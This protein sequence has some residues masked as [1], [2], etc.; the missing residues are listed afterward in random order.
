MYGLKYLH[1]HEGVPAQP[2][3]TLVNGEAH[4]IASPKYTEVADWPPTRNIEYTAGVALLMPWKLSVG[5][6]GTVSE[7][8]LTV[9]SRSSKWRVVSLGKKP[10]S[11]PMLKGMYMSALPGMLP[12]AVTVKV[13]VADRPAASVAVNSTVST[14]GDGLLS[15][16]GGPPV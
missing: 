6:L 3:G 16:G 7:T 4:S 2:S 13:H 11:Q 14:T 9:V 10:R 8:Y 15:V 5:A 1:V 12:A